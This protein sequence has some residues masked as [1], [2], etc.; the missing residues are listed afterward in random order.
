[1]A[2]KRPE[3]K[4]PTRKRVSGVTADASIAARLRALEMAQA[5]ISKQLKEMIAT[6]KKPVRVTISS[7]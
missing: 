5:Q 3:K 7:R 4:K 6:L 1:M 2:K